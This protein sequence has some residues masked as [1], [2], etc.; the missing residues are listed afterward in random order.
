MQELQTI[1]SAALDNVNGGVDWGMAHTVLT[2]GLSCAGGGALI[3]GMVQG[4]WGAAIGGIGAGAA[5]ASTAYLAMKQAQQQQSPQ[6]QTP[7]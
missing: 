7:R 5:C 1:E 2:Q 6:A 3:G 4:P